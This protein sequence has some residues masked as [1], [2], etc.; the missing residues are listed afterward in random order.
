M[1]TT[2]T[3]KR[4][5]ARADE[6]LTAFLDW[7]WRFA[8]AANCLDKLAI[9]FRNFP[10]MKANIPP[11][12]IIFGLVCFALLPRAQAV[13]PPPD[14]GYPGGNTAEGY[15]A[16]DSLTTGTYN[17]GIGLYSLL[18]ITDASLCTGVGAG[19]LLF[20]T[21]A[22][23]TATGAG[24]LFSNTT[25]TENS[26]NGVYALFSNTS[27]P[28]NTATGFQALFS[29]TTGDANV[30]VGIFA[31]S[32]N[33]EGF[34]NT[35]VGRSA[36]ILNVF[37]HDNT[38]IGDG[39]LFNNDSGIFNTAVG[40]IALI[41][42]TDGAHNVAVGAAAGSGITTGDENVVIG[43]AGGFSIGA[44]S[45]NI[46]IGGEVGPAF[47]ESNTIRIADNTSLFP[48]AQCFI[49]GIA[50]V[51]EG[52]P[53]TAVFI[54]TVTGQLG[55]NPSSAR[56]KKDIAPMG[57]TS[58]AI[59]SLRPVT[60]HLKDDNT[61]TPSFGLI[62]EE[63]AKVNPDLIIVD[64]EGKPLTV[65]YEQINAMLLNEFLKEHRKNEEQE[66]T[67]AELKS[68]MTALAATVK[69]QAAQIQKVSAQLAAVSPSRGG[70][71]ASEA[72]PQVVNNDQ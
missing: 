71:E 26:A 14:G 54:N 44:G 66:A 69:E 68:G 55:T 58:E 57:K 27:G 70:L 1:R 35:G 5:F 22:E 17:T 61:S 8:L 10:D 20:N 67:I 48:A 2:A 16:L 19:T 28:F 45:D 46:Y 12:L 36:L 39:A 32:S 64:K 25:G 52:A 56:F 49:G 40:V 37:G 15:R 42:N 59:F 6:K 29:N 18:S 23:N 30:A 7:K 43:N 21:G 38:A 31:L 72:V 47:S 53:M 41:D 34:S 62:A 24:A 13:S 51:N 3:E 50:G 4:F 65:R 60:F 9:F 63:V 33:T 11:V